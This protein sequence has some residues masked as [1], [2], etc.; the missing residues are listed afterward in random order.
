MK[1]SRTLKVFNQFKLP[2]SIDRSTG[3]FLTVYDLQKNSANF[4]RF[5]KLSQSEQVKLMLKRVEQ[6]PKM[7]IAHFCDGATL[8]GDKIVEELENPNS[9]MGKSIMR[10]GAA[11]IE[12]TI[13]EFERRHGQFTGV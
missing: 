6:T 2:V 11:A 1:G 13:E 12:I 8:G 9:E 3:E 4:R 7:E 5:D 10:I